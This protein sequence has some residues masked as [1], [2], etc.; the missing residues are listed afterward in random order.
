MTFQGDDNILKRFTTGDLIV[1]PIL[2]YEQ[3][4]S[5][6]KVDLRIDN[7]FHLVQRIAM[8]SYDPPKYF[9][10]APPK[11]LVKHV[12]PYGTPF[13]L[14]PGEL[15]L[16]PTFESLKVPKDMVGILDGRSS[17]ARLGVL[18][19]ATAGSVDPDFR[20]PLIVELLNVGRVP[21]NL[22]P[23]MRIGAVHF[24]KIEGRVDHPYTGKYQG[25]RNIEDPSSNLH[26][27]PDWPKI[28]A[29]KTQLT[30]FSK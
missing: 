27:D 17:L 22:Y 19:H 3:Q 7:T 16:A 5:G 28:M 8:E 21:V 20:G 29:M 11:Y 24:A 18:V 2:D 15:I 4:I 6:T 14:H 25:F 13:V 12:V 30:N 10:N 9:E 26:K 23:L 1:H